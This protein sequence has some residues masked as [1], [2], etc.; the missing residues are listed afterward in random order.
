M[1]TE[2]GST[3]W[4]VHGEKALLLASIHR[5][6][7]FRVEVKVMCLWCGWEVRKGCGGFEPIG[8]W[9]QNTPEGIGGLL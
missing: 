4:H 2:G 9:N 5:D 6:N 1:G 8:G 7:H 3:I